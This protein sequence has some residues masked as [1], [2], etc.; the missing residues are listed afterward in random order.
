MQKNMKNR[1]KQIFAV[2]SVAEIPTT[3]VL[4]IASLGS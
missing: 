3:S 2:L 1:K 4:V